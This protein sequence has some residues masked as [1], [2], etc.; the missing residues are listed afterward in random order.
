MCEG[1]GSKA[2]LQGDM[3]SLKVGGKRKRL[4]EIE[5]LWDKENKSFNRYPSCSNSYWVCYVLDISLVT[6]IGLISKTVPTLVEFT[7]GV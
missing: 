5:K 4:G 7:V 2:Q 1:V 6:E 3:S